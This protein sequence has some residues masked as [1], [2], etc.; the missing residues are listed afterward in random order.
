M[1]HMIRMILKYAKSSLWTGLKK[2]FPQVLL[3]SRW[4]LGD[5]SDIHFWKSQWLEQLDQL[6]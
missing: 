3:G 4:L 5:D 2:R 6:I 1:D